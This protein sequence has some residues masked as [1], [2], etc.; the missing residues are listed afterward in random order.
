MLYA[1]G[2]TSQ[3]ITFTSLN[4][5]VGGWDGVRFRDGSDYSSTSSMRRCVVEKGTTNLVC[6]NTNQP[7]AKWCTFQDARDQNV[8]LNNASISLEGSTLK[9]AP[10]GLWV[11]SS[12]PSLVSVV[13][14]NH[15]EACIYHNNTCNPT[16]SD[17]TMKDSYVGIR[18]ETPNRDMVN[19]EYSNI[20][21]ENNTANIGVPGG[22]IDVDRSWETNSYAILGTIRLG[23]YYNSSPDR[24][25]LTL[26][27]GT[28]LKFVAPLM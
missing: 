24:C 28:V 6:E 9:N 15:S 18:Y 19:D 20:T 1:V 4:G 8:Y 3:L 16:Y 11:S 23:R 25:R 13:F 21:F 10:R 7:T 2:T 27:P 17:C 14:E 26:S 5:E 22:H 12:A